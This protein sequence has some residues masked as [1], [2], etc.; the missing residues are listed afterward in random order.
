MNQ[1]NLPPHPVHREK[2]LDLSKN[3]VVPKPPTLLD[4]AEEKLPEE[5]TGTSPAGSSGDR[6]SEA[7][8]SES[9]EDEQR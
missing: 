5:G 3:E 2:L 9:G 1:S 4:L 8:A 7:P 6:P